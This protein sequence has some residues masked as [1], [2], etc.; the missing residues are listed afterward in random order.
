MERGSLKLN[1]KRTNILRAE[2][3]PNG[4]MC[5]STHILVSALKQDLLCSSEKKKTNSSLATPSSYSRIRI[6]IPSKVPTKCTDQP[7]QLACP[8]MPLPLSLF[9]VS[10]G[11][12]LPE[13][14]QDI[15]P[16]PAVAPL[17]SPQ[18]VSG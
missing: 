2:A 9:W 16:R 10:R 18:G 17:T 15:S 6:R 8:A 13:F 14:S 11:N 3:E 4:K 1:D 12:L 7:S 5:N